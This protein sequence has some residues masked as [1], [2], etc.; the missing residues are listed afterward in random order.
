VDPS[1][2]E[3]EDGIREHPFSELR[4]AFE[5]YSFSLSSESP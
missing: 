1:V 3:P 2:E 5:D 4:S